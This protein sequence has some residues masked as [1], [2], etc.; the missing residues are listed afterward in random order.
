[1]NADA[2]KYRECFRTVQFYINSHAQIVIVQKWHEVVI[3]SNDVKA[4][5]PKKL[6]HKSKE[7]KLFFI[8]LLCVRYNIHLFP[9]LLFSC[10][11]STYMSTKKKICFK[12]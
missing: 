6:P 9:Y 11:P 12:C 4:P 5:S 10:C 8:I 7:L 2:K 3:C 1:M